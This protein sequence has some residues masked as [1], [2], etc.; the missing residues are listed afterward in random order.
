MESQS[1]LHLS[2]HTHCV[3]PG[4]GL[5]VGVEVG[6]GN[7]RCNVSFCFFLKKKKNIGK[8][9]I[10]VV[11]TFLYNYSLF[12]FC[13]FVSLLSVWHLLFTVKTMGV[14]LW[15]ASTRVGSGRECWMRVGWGL[16]VEGESGADSNRVP[17]QIWKGIRK[18]NNPASIWCLICAGSTQN[19]QQ[20]CKPNFQKFS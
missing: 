2:E 17:T 5:D 16:P 7:C 14:H 19:F 6:G 4:C 9:L 3:T 11:F 20:N 13:M 8:F 12:L 1:P 15:P 18:K 10:F